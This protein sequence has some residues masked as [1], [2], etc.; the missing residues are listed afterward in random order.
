MAIGPP[1][2]TGGEAV[3]LG[4]VSSCA[5]SI[6]LGATSGPPS[7][8][9]TVVCAVMGD[10]VEGSAGTAAVVV[11]GFGL[12]G[13]VGAGVGA[14]VPA[15]ALSSAGGKAEVKSSLAL[16][17]AAAWVVCDPIIRCALEGCAGT[18]GETV[19]SSPG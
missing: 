7:P 9:G 12:V 4:G 8:V 16:D 17:G 2:A 14:G 1:A 5:V 18:T 10:G 11:V 6:G 15:K 19:V 13:F 3:V